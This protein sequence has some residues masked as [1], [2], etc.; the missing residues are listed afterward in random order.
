M[1][2]PILMGYA[3]FVCLL[4][5]RVHTVEAASKQLLSATEERF[6][7][8]EHFRVPRNLP[9]RDIGEIKT[10]LYVSDYERSGIST[11]TAVLNA[12][13]ALKNTK[14]KAELIFDKSAYEL[15][16]SGTSKHIFELSGFVDKVVNGNNCRIVIKNPTVGFIKLST[17]ENC[18]IQ[19]F[20]IDYDPLPYV[21]S[22]ITSV[23]KT[24]NTFD[25]KVADG[26]SDFDTPHV[27]NA[28]QNWSMLKNPDVPGRN[29]VGARAHYGVAGTAR[30]NGQYFR[31]TVSKNYIPDFEVGDVFIKIARYN[32]SVIVNLNKCERISIIGVSVLASP[33]GAFHLSYCSEIN[34]LDSSV[35]MAEGRYISSNADC[36]HHMYTS[37]GP[38]IEGCLFEGQSDDTFNLKWGKALIKDQTSANK[39][40]VSKEIKPGE[41]LWIYNPREGVLIDTVRVNSATRENNQT[42]HLV[43]AKALPALLTGRDDQRG[44][45]IY[46]DSERNQS[47]VFRN[48]VVRNHR[49]Y[50][51]LIQ[52]S[53]GLIEN[54]EFDNSSN[55]AITI[56]NGVDWGEGFVAEHLLIRNN[57]FRQNGYDQ[58]YINDGKACI[59]I[60]M[61][62]LEN[63]DA[64]GQWCGVIGAPWKGMNHI[65]IEDNTFI[66][67]NKKAIHVESADHVVI[68][69]NI[70][71]AQKNPDDIVIYTQN[72][73]VSEEDNK[74]ESASIDT[75]LHNVDSIK[76]ITC[77]D[78]SG[79]MIFSKIY[80]DVVKTKEIIHDM[81]DNSLFS[82]GIY[83]M[84]ALSVNDET[85]TKKFFV[86]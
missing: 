79:Q 76:Q 11:T 67:W 32:G 44:D 74:F 25:C 53:Y 45:I 41:L 2:L 26:F 29:K 22:V 20:E 36:L 70:F 47:F 17:S 10:T 4:C 49:R 85:I 78:I 75:D 72:A 71:S 7:G 68:K 69:G 58:S 33:A 64:P 46:V 19:N 83:L 55:S 31:I 65:R 77:Y 84:K 86:F 37:I 40:T 63:P 42:Y 52:S 51:V 27:K 60:R 18:I 50:G 5:L 15:E 8:T 43:V 38:W 30:I 66:D 54:N 3:L 61:S 81:S 80:Q 59:Y 56:E 34:I 39:I 21:Q 16:Y 9:F 24:N 6:P 28:P 82:R 1:R 73:D 13:N 35:K 23:N 12:L 62:K 48:N 57:T 14:G